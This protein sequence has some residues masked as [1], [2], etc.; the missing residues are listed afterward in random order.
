[1]NLITLHY[2]RMMLSAPQNSSA[3]VIELKLI[4]PD[5]ISS[6]EP[7]PTDPLNSSRVT[8]TNGNTYYVM[9]TTQQIEMMARGRQVLTDES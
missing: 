5:H 2:K 9:E 1:M 8:M 3:T 7:V 4:N 6:I